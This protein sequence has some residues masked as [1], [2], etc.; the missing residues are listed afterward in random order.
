MF[1]KFGKACWH[2]A[3][4]LHPC[5]SPADTDGTSE[6]SVRI[7]NQYHRNADWALRLSL[8]SGRYLVTSLRPELFLLSCCFPSI[9]FIRAEDAAFLAR[10]NVLQYTR[11]PH[12]ISS[13]WASYLPIGA[14]HP[15]RVLLTSPRTHFHTEPHL[16]LNVSLVYLLQVHRNHLTRVL[17]TPPSPD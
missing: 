16:L 7:V 17:L 8:N 13:I 1:G 3:E 14:S 15:T 4:I 11:R 5:S 9:F 10:E 6:R 2:Q 12:L